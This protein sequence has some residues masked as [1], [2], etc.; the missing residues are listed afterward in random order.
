MAAKAPDPSCSVTDDILTASDLP[1]GTLCLG[2]DLYPMCGFTSS[3][4]L[5]LALTPPTHPYAVYLFQRGHGGSLVK[6]P[7]GLGD[8]HVICMASA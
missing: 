4:S 1:D 2:Y 5:T 3:G 7:P 6:M 8:Y